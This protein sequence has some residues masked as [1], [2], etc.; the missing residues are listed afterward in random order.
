LGRTDVFG[1]GVRFGLLMQEFDTWHLA[2]TLWHFDAVADHDTAPIDAQ[3][4]RE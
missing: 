3:R 1:L 2:A 4:L